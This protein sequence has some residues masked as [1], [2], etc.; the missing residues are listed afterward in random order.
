MIGEQSKEALHPA[1]PFC[2]SPTEESRTMSTLRVLTIALLT[3]SL[4][5]CAHYY[6]VNDPA[7]GKVFYTEKVERKGSAVE[8]K[9][10]QT[11]GEVTLQNSEI[12]QIDKQAYEAGVGTAK[13]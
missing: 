8:F 12:T 10:A 11:G 2:V 1:L 5:A 13:K 7:T 6:K 4:T 9:D 3:V